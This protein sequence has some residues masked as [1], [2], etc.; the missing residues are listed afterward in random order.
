MD[1]LFLSLPLLQAAGQDSTT[2]LITT[3]LMMAAVFGV[4]Y[5]LII[6]PQRKKQKDTKQMLESLKKVT[7]LSQLVVSA[8]RYRM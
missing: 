6:R 5:F 1:K 4:F 7:G 3:V 8:E 2:S